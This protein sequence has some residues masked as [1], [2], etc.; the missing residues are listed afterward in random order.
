MQLS[1]PPPLLSMQGPTSEALCHPCELP[2]PWF[3][4]QPEVLRCFGCTCAQTGVQAGA[5][6]LAPSWPSPAPSLPQEPNPSQGAVWVQQS[7]SEE[8]WGDFLQPRES[9]RYVPSCSVCPPPTQTCASIT[10]FSTQL[11]GAAPPAAWS[12]LIPDIASSWP[13]LA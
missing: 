10:Q 3:S 6:P 13:C 7:P 2:R 12:D 9:L 1:L 5:L 8:G 4:H 11:E